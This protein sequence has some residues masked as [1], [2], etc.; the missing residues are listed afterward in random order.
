MGGGGCGTAPEPGFVPVVG[1]R[2]YPPAVRGAGAPCGATASARPRVPLPRR[3]DCTPL[4][5]LDDARALGWLKPVIGSLLTGCRPWGEFG[6]APP[7]STRGCTIPR[8]RNKFKQDAQPSF[9][10]RD[11]S[12]ENRNSVRP[13]RSQLAAEIRGPG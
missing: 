8:I 7:L 12:A 2:A 3:C 5:R 10:V 13:V 9:P 4:R 1:W 6:I 11:G